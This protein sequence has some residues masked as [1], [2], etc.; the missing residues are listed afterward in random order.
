[1]RLT[2]ADSAHKEEAKTAAQKA[3]LELDS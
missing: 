3:A 2:S 1:M